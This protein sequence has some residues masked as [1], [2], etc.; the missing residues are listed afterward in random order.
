MKTLHTL[1]VSG[2]V[3]CMGAITVGCGGDDTSDTKTDAGGDVVTSDS[4]PADGS[5]SDANDGGGPQ[6]FTEFVKGLILTQTS[7]KTL[8]T[9]TEDKTFIDSH[10]GN[11]FPPSFFP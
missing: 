11:A 9:T 1:F 8:P 10:N 2:V 4:G 6:E 3:L 7:D 5:T